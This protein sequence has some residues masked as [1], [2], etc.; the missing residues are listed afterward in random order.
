MSGLGEFEGQIDDGSLRV[1][2]VSGAERLETADAPTLRGGHRPGLHQLARRPRPSRHRRRH[3]RAYID[4][5]RRCTTPQ[6]W[7]DALEKNGWTDNFATGEEFETFLD[8]TGRARPHDADRPG[9]GLSHDPRR[10]GR[11]SRGPPGQPPIEET[12]PVPAAH[13]AR[14]DGAA[15]STPRSTAWRRSSPWPAP[16]SSTT[17]ASSASG[18]S[19]DFRAALHLRLRRRRRAA[20]RWRSPSPSP[21]PAGDVAEAEEGEDVDLGGRATYAPSALLARSSSSSTSP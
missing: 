9:P 19:A 13:H 20:G 21:R 7:Q 5:F 11:P 15:S 16:T 10:L 18:M 14:D 4:L 17:A 2:A 8:R 12:P 1:L 6:A 3:S